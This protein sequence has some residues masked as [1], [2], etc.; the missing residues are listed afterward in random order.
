M[1]F[2]AFRVVYTVKGLDSHAKHVF[3]CQKSYFRVH[4]RFGEFFSIMA[5][6]DVN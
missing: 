1:L 3:L 6:A 5:L 4:T 2:C